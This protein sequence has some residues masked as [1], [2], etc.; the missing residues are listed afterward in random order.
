MAAVTG[1]S[2]RVEAFVKSVV[3]VVD[4]SLRVANVRDG[5]EINIVKGGYVVC[6]GC[7]A[8]LTRIAGTCQHC[9]ARIES[10]SI[11]ITRGR[12]RWVGSVRAWIAAHR[13]VRQ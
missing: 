7:S 5:Y 2:P 8:R 11:E 12:P 13:V 4:R 1:G 10:R 9:G 6:P 3:E